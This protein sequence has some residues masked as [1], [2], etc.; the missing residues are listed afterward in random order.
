M[1]RGAIDCDEKERDEQWIEGD[2]ENQTA[3]FIEPGRERSRETHG[4][5]HR[6]MF[7]DGGGK[8]SDQQ[9]RAGAQDGAEGT[10]DCDARTR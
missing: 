10:R 4:Q 6:F 9:R 5:S 1:R 8:I 3:V 2:F 7:A